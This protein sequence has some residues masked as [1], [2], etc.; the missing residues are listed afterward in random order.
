[1]G[2][3]WA[4]V[5]LIRENMLSET[6]R[7]PSIRA[8]KNVG[9]LLPWLRVA[10]WLHFTHKAC[11]YFQTMKKE[12]MQVLC[13]TVSSFLGRQAALEVGNQGLSLASS[14]VGGNQA[15]EL[16][17][18]KGQ[19]NGGGNG[20]VESRV[21]TPRSCLT[22]CE[23]RDVAC[24]R[25]RARGDSGHQD[26]QNRKSSRKRRTTGSFHGTG[27]ESIGL[28]THMWRAPPRTMPKSMFLRS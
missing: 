26:C 2:M 19:E 10:C 18:Q 15:Q 27:A 7:I 11:L 12:I 1:M 9:R 14:N 25:M 6:A 3:T 17:T 24:A 13:D 23:K 22:R 8:S 20:V 28:R 16:V 21:S 4:M 5:Q